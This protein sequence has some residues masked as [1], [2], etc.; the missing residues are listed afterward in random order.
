M[1][2]YIIMDLENPNARGNSI[3]SIAIIVI[4][5]N[6]IIDKKYSLINPE[7]RFDIKNS[8]ITGITSNMILQSPTLK[9]YWY[10]IK[11]LLENNI[12]VGHNV[13]YDLSVLSKSLN[14]YNIDVPLFN[15]C[16]TLELSRQYLNLDSYKLTSIAQFLNVNYNPHN[17]LEDA[18]ATYYLFRYLNEHYNM[19]KL[20]AKQYEY[21]FTVKD[22]IDS[23]L[24][25]NINSLYG[26]IK[27]I[28]YDGIINQYEIGLLN[29][30][31]EENMIYK[32]YSLFNKII[33]ELSS[34]LEDGII[35]EY[36]RIELLCLVN[37]IQSSNMY[38]ET[39]LNLQILQGILEGIACDK[40]IVIEE[41]ENLKIWLI[42]NDYLSGVYPY[43]KILLIVNKVLEDKI[44]TESEKAELAL[45]FNEI[46]NPVCSNKKNIELNGKTFCL[47]GDFKSGTK[48]EMKQKLENLGAVEKS[49]V[50]AKLNYLFVGG[51]GSD[52]WK[53]G[54][55]GGKIAKAQE[56]QEKGSLIQIISEEDL[57]E[58]INN[59]LCV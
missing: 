19:D 13:I 40:K 35:T 50:S 15:Y 17:A 3:C 14:R 28:N 57:F 39:T 18:I 22:N 34:I 45:S 43:D 29:N 10:E 12:I 11:E 6:E 16:C 5:N 51:L 33:T 42:K 2:N 48:S 37:S 49:G 23:K 59:M 30:W 27:G 21:E 55:I 52:A 8:E 38:N 47:T 56:L 31:I 9:E 20:Q 24:T 7:D 46:L 26:I 25:S 53:Y 41:V 32:Q 4:K 54:N 36:E 58:H 44:L 1:K